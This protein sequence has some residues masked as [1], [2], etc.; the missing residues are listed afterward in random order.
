[1]P[2]ET[3]R[4]IAEQGGALRWR[5]LKLPSGRYLHVAVTR[6]K[7]PRGGQTVASEP[8]ESKGDESA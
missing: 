8:K 1:V 3:E 4:K 5:T 6:D 7:G 2:E